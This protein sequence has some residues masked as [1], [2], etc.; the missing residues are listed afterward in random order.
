MDFLGLA[1]GSLL[2]LEETFFPLVLA[3]LKLQA[4]ISRVAEKMI[5]THVY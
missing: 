1:V 5:I 2:L 3:S 4:A